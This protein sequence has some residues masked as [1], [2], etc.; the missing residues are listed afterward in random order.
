MAGAAGAVASATAG[1]AG[2]GGHGGSNGGAAP[3]GGAGEGGV[4]GGM[5]T[6]GPPVVKGPGCGRP[7]P[8]DQT[9]LPGEPTG[10]KRYQV[11]LAGRSLVQVDE[12]TSGLERSMWVRVPADY[13]PDRAYRVIYLGVDHSDVTANLAALR[14]FDEA[15]GGSEQAIYVALDFP[16]LGPDFPPSY[17]V[18]SSPNSLEWEAFEVLQGVVSE[19][20]CVDEER[21]FVAGRGPGGTLANMYGCYFSGERGGQR[22]FANAYRIRAQAAIH[23][24]QA[25]GLPDCGGPVAA[26]F[27]RRDDLASFD[28]AYTRVLEQ[29]G[30]EGSSRKPWVAMPNVCVRF[31]DCPAEFPVVVCDVYG[32]PAPPEM[33]IP[34]V[35]AFFDAVSSGVEPPTALPGFEPLCKDGETASCASA[36]GELGACA[37]GT[38]TCQ[39]AKWGLCSIPRAPADTC[40]PGNDDS[41]DGQP[42]SGCACRWEYP[43]TPQESAQRFDTSAAEVV[44]DTATGLMWTKQVTPLATQ[45]AGACDTG[46]GGFSDWR[47]PSVAELTS[48]VDFSRQTPAI[49]L[50]AFPGTPPELFWTITRAFSGLW[51]V[52]FDDGAA[53][54][55]MDLAAPAHTRCVRTPTTNQPACFPTASRYDVINAELVEDHSSGLTW[56]RSTTGA[57]TWPQAA[58]A[59]AALGGGFR[60]PSVREL[61]ALVELD[62]VPTTDFTAFPSDGFG[63]RRLWTSTSFPNAPTRIWTVDFD[64]GSAYTVFTDDSGGASAARCVR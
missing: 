36:L 51:Y 52:S 35:T 27:F 22:Q 23:G 26:L 56:R 2:A 28:G 63:V 44:T 46:V 12:P 21:V 9:T 29:N 45:P 6:G 61:L 47:V 41:C 17:D 31:V 18:H 10:F 11:T 38:T 34:A 30:C 3:H 7:L 32:S 16:E 19:N 59:C 60:L 25:R 5:S 62:G 39:D 50:A 24:G 53:T 14:L 64:T 40:A 20:Y 57:L 55:V 4:P 13:D 1:S 43:Q 49:D 42:Y 58:A 48:L 8:A 54:K 33:T 15:A 37:A